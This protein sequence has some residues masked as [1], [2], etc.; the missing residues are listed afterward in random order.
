MPVKLVGWK[1]H[2]RACKQYSFQSYNTFTFYAMRVF[3]LF[4]FLFLMIILSHASAK[5]KT[6]KLK[7]FKLR[8]FTGRFQ[9]TWQWRGWNSAWLYKYQIHVFSPETPACLHNYIQRLHV[10]RDERELQDTRPKWH[11]GFRNANKP[12]LPLPSSSFKKR[13]PLQTN[14]STGLSKSSLLKHWL[15]TG[16]YWIL[17]CLTQHPDGTKPTKKWAQLKP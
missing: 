9:V 17:L 8:T 3:C 11:K 13:G 14:Q 1:M 12:L 15:T 10:L 6:K 16:V 4:L 2:G 7:G 5:K